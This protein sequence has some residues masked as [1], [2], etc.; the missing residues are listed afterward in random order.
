MLR[1]KSRPTAHQASPPGSARPG[2]LRAKVRE[3]PNVPGSVRTAV[4]IA[5]LALS[6]SLLSSHTLG[7]PLERNASARR[8]CGFC[9]SAVCV[10]RQTD[11]RRE[12]R[13]YGVG[14][15]GI[16][17]RWPRDRLQL[18]SSEVAAREWANLLRPSRTF[19]LQEP[20]HLD[21]RGSGNQLTQGHVRINSEH[22]PKHRQGRWR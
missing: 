12:H 10:S 17:I 16:R 7:R 3:A 4:S 2:E 8:P 22:A 6:R 5:E 1:R 19:S 13:I 9:A 14:E 18:V 20:A 15:R 11:R 21:L